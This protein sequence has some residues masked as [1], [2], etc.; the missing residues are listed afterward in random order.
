MKLFILLTALIM[1]TS[2]LVAFADEAG[3][4]QKVCHIRG[5]FFDELADDGIW[6]KGL[7]NC[8][9]GDVVAF[10]QEGTRLN[11]MIVAIA[12]VCEISTVSMVN[13][14]VPTAAVCIYSGRILPVISD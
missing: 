10:D 5:K 1:T 2:P 7:T 12:R 6:A 11:D 14:N 13:R 4:G 3:D 8:T 9:K